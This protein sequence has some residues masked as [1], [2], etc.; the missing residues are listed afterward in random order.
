MED[1]LTDLHKLG[2][3]ELQWV[4]F[5]LI[6]FSSLIYDFNTLIITLGNALMTYKSLCEWNN[7]GT[8]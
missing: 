8:P 4:F 3:F 1:I 5:F 6:S 7:V 2:L